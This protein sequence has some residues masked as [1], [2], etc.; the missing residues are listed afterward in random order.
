L[1]PGSSESS[2]HRFAWDGI[3][4]SVPFSWNLSVQQCRK[5]VSSIEL[6]DDTS[7]RLQLDWTRP[8][9]KIDIETVRRRYSKLSKNLV[10]AADRVEPVAGLAEGWTAF[11]YV[12][13]DRRCLVIA[14]FL[15]STGDVFCF[16]RVHFSPRERKRRARTLDLIFS[17][18]RVHA[19]DIVPW[20]FYDVAFDLGVE[21]SLNGTSLH[22]GRKLM[23]FQWG[24]RRL[25][26][27]HFS[28]ADVILKRN[29]IGQWAVDFLKESKVVCGPVFELDEDG[30]IRSRRTLR[31]PLGHY[32]EIGRQCFRYQAGYRHLPKKNQIVLWVFNHRR[33]EDA[34]KF[35]RTFDPSSG[36]QLSGQEV[37]C[38]DPDDAEG[39]AGTS[40]PGG[41]RDRR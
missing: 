22:A 8:R 23:I 35:S 16:F 31:Y 13:P 12:M 20:E 30:S 41:N 38:S 10:G 25:F 36:A 40:G 2:T 11:R 14:Y 26:I 27:W 18:F 6:E 39:F 28:L 7:L 3:S 34:E 17:S 4:F 33:P 24:L 5:G 32:E 9:S 29:D 1:A 15:A 21:F 19:G 37:D